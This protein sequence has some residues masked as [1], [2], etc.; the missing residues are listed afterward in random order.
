M[1]AK[2]KQINPNTE[3][4]DK[5]TRKTI[6]L[7]RVNKTNETHATPQHAAE[8]APFKA[9]NSEETSRTVTGP[10]RGVRLSP[11]GVGT[12]GR[13]EGASQNGLVTDD[14]IERSDRERR[15]TRKALG[16]PGRW[17]PPLQS[18]NVFRYRHQILYYHPTPHESHTTTM[19]SGAQRFM[20]DNQSHHC[21][22]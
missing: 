22:Q 11:T 4:H 21:R 10:R 20:M 1:R 5:G 13:E 14:A 2:S 7:P 6:I 8:N 15:S 3:S 12:W 17:P 9:P 19:I 16:C 18:A